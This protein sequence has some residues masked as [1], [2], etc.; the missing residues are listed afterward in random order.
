MVNKKNSLK[1][2]LVRDRVWD[3]GRPF[4]LPVKITFHAVAALGYFAGDPFGPQDNRHRSR[5]A[6][7]FGM[8]IEGRN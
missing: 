6:A 2:D 1:I 3:V 5:R 4:D 7:L 8:D